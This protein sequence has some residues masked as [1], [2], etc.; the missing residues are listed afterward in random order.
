MARAAA[1]YGIMASHLEQ[2]GVCEQV[3]GGDHVLGHRTH[4]RG[5]P[6]HLRM[7]SHTVH[8]Q[9]TSQQLITAGLVY[10]LDI[11]RFAHLHV[12]EPLQHGLCLEDHGLRQVVQRQVAKRRVQ[13][14]ALGALHT[15]HRLEPHADKDASEVVT[16]LQIR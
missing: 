5:L 16:W 4:L 12:G 15:F 3:E 9:V 14:R 2:G 11:F 6:F 7:A 1:A 13:V 10:I 8:E